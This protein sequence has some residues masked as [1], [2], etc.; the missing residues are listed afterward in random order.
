M[1]RQIFFLAVVAVSSCSL[2]QSFSVI[3][4][5]GSSPFTGDP[6][7]A[8]FSRTSTWSSAPD[9]G[10]ESR[11]E[12]IIHLDTVEGGAGDGLYWGGGLFQPTVTFHLRFIPTL[13]NPVPSPS[14]Y[15]VWVKSRLKWG[16]MVDASSNHQFVWG[17]QESRMDGKLTILSIDSLLYTI[18]AFAT[19]QTPPDWESTPSSN[20]NHTVGDPNGSGDWSH[21]GSYYFPNVVF[22]YQNGQWRASVTVSTKDEQ[23]SESIW[24]FEAQNGWLISM[25]KAGVTRQF[26]VS[27]I[28][29]QVFSGW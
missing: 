5:N 29:D 13:Q 18:G 20:V 23:N 4:K 26:R 17:P 1:K 9:N 16:T 24:L 3:S 28:G 2:S 14:G 21:Q 11:S 8:F 12:W 7:T 15:P 19:Y 22:A 25:L 27:K 6:P 10:L